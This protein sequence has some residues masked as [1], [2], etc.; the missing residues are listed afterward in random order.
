MDSLICHYSSTSDEAADGYCDHQNVYMA[1]LTLPALAISLIQTYTFLSYFVTFGI[2]MALIGMGMMFGYL[3]EKLNTDQEVPGEIKIF[4]VAQVFGNIGV[5]MFL[6]EGNAV[7]INVRA[8]TKNQHRYPTILTTSF[9]SVISMFMVF[10]ILA[11]SVYKDQC[12][13]IFV[14]NLQ[15]VNGFVTFVYTCVCINCFISYPV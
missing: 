10:G 6:F 9:I 3:G 4:D 8:E 5:A 15:P 1:C 13:S 7:V 14:L 12:N 11:Y 2:L